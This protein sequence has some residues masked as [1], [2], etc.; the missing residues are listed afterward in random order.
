MF[1]DVSEVLDASVIRAMS[2]F[3]W[4]QQ[5]PSKR[6][7]ISIEL[8]RAHNPRRQLVCVFLVSTTPRE[9]EGCCCADS[10][11]GMCGRLMRDEWCCP[12]Q[13]RVPQV[14][15]RSRL[16]ACVSGTRNA[17]VLFPRTWGSSYGK[18]TWCRLEGRMSFLSAGCD[19]SFSATFRRIWGPRTPSLIDTQ[20]SLCVQS[21]RSLLATRLKCWGV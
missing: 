10:P 18:V 20:D 19:V 5:A 8:H 16:S 12:D 21:G 6:R 1:T 4:R 3:W 14:P 9:R 2:K 15:A 7:W 17:S 13:T 11:T